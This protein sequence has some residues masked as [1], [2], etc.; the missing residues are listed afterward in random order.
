MSPSMAPKANQKDIVLLN[1]YAAS[2]ENV[3]KGKGISAYLYPHHRDTHK[4]NL[5]IGDVIFFI[6]PLDPRQRC[7]KRILAMP[8]DIVSTTTAGSSTLPPKE[9]AMIRIPPGHI[10]VEGDASAAEYKSDRTDVPSNRKSR[11]SRTYGPV[12]SGPICIAPYY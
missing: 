12:S 3:F 8:G 10:W 9:G 2:T 11:D 1:K 7:T 4:Q 5:Q 6:S